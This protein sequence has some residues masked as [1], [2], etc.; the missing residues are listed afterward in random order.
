MARK[1][2]NLKPRK[3]PF[4][5]QFHFEFIECFGKIYAENVFHNF[6]FPRAIKENAEENF[7]HETKNIEKLHKLDMKL[8]LPLVDHNVM[9]I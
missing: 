5:S 1:K 4:I 3:F 8:N 7:S 6:S 2:F 9:I